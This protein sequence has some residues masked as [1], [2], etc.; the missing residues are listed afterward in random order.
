[1]HLLTPSD[2]LQCMPVSNSDELLI[3]D[4]CLEYVSI[5]GTFQQAGENAFIFISGY[6]GFIMDTIVTDFEH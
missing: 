2:G 6:Y 3:N 5:D 4:Q 1:M